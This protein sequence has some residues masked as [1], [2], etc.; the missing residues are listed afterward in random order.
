MQPDTSN[1][2]CNKAMIYFE[3]VSYFNA[4]FR[5]LNCVPIETI[6]FVWN[7]VYVVICLVVSPV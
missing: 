5:Y 7:H 4:Q 1:S 6:V 2:Q 3:F